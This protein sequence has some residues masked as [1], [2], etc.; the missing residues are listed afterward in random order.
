[1]QVKE[2]RQQL[3]I[4]DAIFQENL[5]PSADLS[6]FNYD[7]GTWDN[8][9]NI[10]EDADLAA[11]LKEFQYSSDERSEPSDELTDQPAKKKVRSVRRV[12]ISPVGTVTKSQPKKDEDKDEDEDG[13]EGPVKG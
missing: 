1:M 9:L 6:V 8:T 10:A 2:L 4:R 7:D 12:T 13:D 5:M 3:I 11:A